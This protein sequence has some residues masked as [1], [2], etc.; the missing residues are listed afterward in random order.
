MILIASLKKQG[1]IQFSPNRDGSVKFFYKRLWS[2]IM[3]D[4]KQVR[5]VPLLVVRSTKAEP[6]PVPVA[7]SAQ[8]F[9]ASGNAWNTPNPQHNAVNPE[10]L[11]RTNAFGDVCQKP[12]VCGYDDWGPL[13]Y[14]REAHKKLVRVEKSARG[15]GVAQARRLANIRRAFIA[16]K[17]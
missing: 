14:D 17:G 16:G 11:F 9:A 7:G 3:W 12:H 15:E 13:N 1:I 5:L 10:R 8:Q 6:D 4:G 2:T